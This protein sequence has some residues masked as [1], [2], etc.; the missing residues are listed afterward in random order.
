MLLALLVLAQLSGASSYNISFSKSSGNFKSV[1]TIMDRTSR[2][3]LPNYQSGYK[4]GIQ[5]ISTSH[6]SGQAQSLYSTSSK[7]QKSYGIA[8]NYSSAS[9]NYGGHRSG[10]NYTG[11]HYSYSAPTLAASKIS[12]LADA[13]SLK[14]DY[15]GKTTTASLQASA[16]SI[17]SGGRPAIRRESTLISYTD[18]D[19]PTSHVNGDPVGDGTYYYWDG[20]EGVWV[21]YSGK[22]DQPEPFPVG[23]IPWL[24]MILMLSAFII[25]KAKTKTKKV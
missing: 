20:D 4:A 16:N 17:V 11:A 15:A 3:N 22:K 19:D 14:A 18:D 24:M 5:A 23:N 10:S 6:S 13:A 8:G 2:R 21:I 12:G 25:A 1:N 7:T 9:A